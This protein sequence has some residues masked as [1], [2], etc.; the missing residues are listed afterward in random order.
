VALGIVLS[1]ATAAMSSFAS[2]T[3]PSRWSAAAQAEGGGKD[4]GETEKQAS[5][6]FPGRG[7]S[8]ISADSLMR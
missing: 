5:H 8:G 3:T 2:G 7:C 1:C 4:K 6:R